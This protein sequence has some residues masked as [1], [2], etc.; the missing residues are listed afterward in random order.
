MKNKG[1]YD[2]TKKQYLKYLPK[3]NTLLEDILEKNDEYYLSKFIFYLYNYENWFY[4]KV[5]RK[6][7]KVKKNILLDN[8]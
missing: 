7:K 1:Q 6:G 4:N 3:L 5:G 8:Y 2:E